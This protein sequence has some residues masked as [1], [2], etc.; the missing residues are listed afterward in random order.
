MACLS[1]AG[2]VLVD[3]TNVE[4]SFVQREREKEGIWS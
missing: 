2:V 4:D 3:W 1:V